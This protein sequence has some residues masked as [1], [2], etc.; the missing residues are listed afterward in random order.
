MRKLI[1]PLKENHL[2]S[3]AY[4]KGN[5]RVAKLCAVYVLKNYKKNPDGTPM[6]TKLGI[7]VNRKLGKAC[8]R[9]RVKRLIREAY[10]QNYC[11][12]KDGYFIIIAARAAAF[13]PYIKTQDMSK[14]LRQIVSDES[15]YEFKKAPQKKK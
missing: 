8:K 4:T 3:K 5:C 13:A 9:N 10:R 6:K 7:T 12:I 11:H 1:L 2:F 14:A 15:F